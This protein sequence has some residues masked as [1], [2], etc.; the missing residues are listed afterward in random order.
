MSRICRSRRLRSRWAVS[1]HHR[2]L[3][4]RGRGKGATKIAPGENLADRSEKPGYRIAR[5][6]QNVQGVDTSRFAARGQRHRPRRRRHHRRGV[7]Q[8]RHVAGR[9]RHHAADRP[10][11]QPR[12]LQE[13]LRR[14]QRRVRPSLA[15]AQKAGAPTIDYGIFLN[16]VI[17]FLIVAFVVFLLVRQVN[18]LKPPQQAPPR[19]GDARLSVLVRDKGKATRCPQCTSQLA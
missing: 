6:G 15:E 10:A 3:R 13:P 7:R 4:R 9:R 17:E 18:R 12:G 5:G 14:A 11:H 2:C 8:D 16:T 1:H 19:A